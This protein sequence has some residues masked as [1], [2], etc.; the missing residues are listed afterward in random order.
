M[1]RD[2][3]RD[4]LTKDQDEGGDFLEA[5]EGVISRIPYPDMSH[6][7]DVQQAPSSE[8]FEKVVF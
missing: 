6:H 5:T 7:F 2:I 4:A 1:V 8:H 3:E